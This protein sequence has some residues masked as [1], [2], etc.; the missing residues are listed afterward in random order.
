MLPPGR[1][2]SWLPLLQQPPCAIGI[3]AASHQ[4]KR[5]G[6]GRSRLLA[7]EGV[8]PAL[9]SGCISWAE[10]SIIPV[11]EADSTYTASAPATRCTGQRVTST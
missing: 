2:R 6:K 1:A 4:G 7:Q 10:I 3:L 9:T 11:F 5:S 8:Q